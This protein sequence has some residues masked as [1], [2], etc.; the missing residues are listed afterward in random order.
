MIRV[1]RSCTA[2]LLALMLAGGGCA[3]ALGETAI[4]TGCILSAAGLYAVLRY[5]ETRP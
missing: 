4:L 1:V 3:G 5:L 2:A